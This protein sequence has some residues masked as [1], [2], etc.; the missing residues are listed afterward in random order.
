MLGKL[1]RGFES[2]P[3]RHTFESPI[4]KV[5]VTPCY[6]LAT[7]LDAF[8]GASKIG[9]RARRAYYPF[10]RGTVC[11]GAA[12]AITVTCW[13]TSPKFTSTGPTM[14]RDLPNCFVDGASDWRNGEATFLPRSSFIDITSASSTRGLARSVRLGRKDCDV[15]VERLDGLR[16]YLEV[17]SITPNL[18]QSKNGG[19]V[20]SQSKHTCKTQRVRSG[21]EITQQ[22]RETQK[23][24]SKAREN[25]AVIELNDPSI[26]GD[27]H[28][29]SS[30]VR[31]AT[32][33]RSAES[34]SV[35]ID[36]GFDW[37]SSLFRLTLPRAPPQ[38]CDL[39]LIL[40]TTN[41]AVSC[42]TPSSRCPDV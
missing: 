7:V 9:S 21:K 39:V 41:R 23:Q 12:S 2:H 17:L 4:T 10:P 27:F 31:R 38:R 6:R 25:Y 14:R 8:G 30:P 20:C 37:K 34:P 40:E 19:P 42:I 11:R 1:N 36:E 15:I 24:M 26:V 16:A 33:S 29:L 22:N 28:V 3:L 32:R 13:S 35:K 18:E 5:P